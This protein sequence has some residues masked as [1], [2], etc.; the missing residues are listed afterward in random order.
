MNHTPFNPEQY[1][2]STDLTGRAQ[3]KLTVV[4]T[5]LQNGKLRWV[6]QCNCGNFVMRKSKTIT[7]PTNTADACEACRK[8][9]PPLKKLK[10]LP[11]PTAPTYNKPAER[12][13]CGKQGFSSEKAAKQAMRSRLNKGANVSRLRTYFC[14]SCAKWHL[15]STFHRIK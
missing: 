9:P 12:T 14:K 8:I 7:N 13:R 6:C 10:D 1:P 5:K 2:N 4:G 15:T 3:G 11:E